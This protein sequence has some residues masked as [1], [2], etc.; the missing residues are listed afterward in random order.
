MS[1]PLIAV[2]GV[3]A[4]GKSTLV[5]GLQARGWNARHVVQ[6]HSY[7]PDMWQRI[8]QPDLLICLDASLE[9]IRQRRRDPEM[10]AWLIDEERHRLRHAREFCALYVQTDMLTPDQVLGRALE[11]LG[12][13][14]DRTQ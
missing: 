2:V 10:P 14:E 13:I 11:F 5:R 8:T 7:V 6:E 9:I 12:V 4:S 1:G 3:C